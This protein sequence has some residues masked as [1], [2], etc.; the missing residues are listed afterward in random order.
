MNLYQI[1]RSNLAIDIYNSVTPGHRHHHHRRR[2][3][4]SEA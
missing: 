4:K 1:S 2:V 3:M